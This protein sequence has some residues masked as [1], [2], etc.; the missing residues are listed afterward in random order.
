LEARWLFEFYTIGDFFKHAGFLRPV[1]QIWENGNFSVS[2]VMFS[3]EPR[4]P[5]LSE[6]YSFLVF[7][8][9]KVVFHQK[10]SKSMGRGGFFIK[11]QR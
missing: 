11:R 2:K 4:K 10:G 9:K 8:S 3:L 5:G 7:F 1:P 6:N